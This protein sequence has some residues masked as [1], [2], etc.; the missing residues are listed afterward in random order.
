MTKGKRIILFLLVLMI[1]G[2]VF[3]A[4]QQN[5][6][7]VPLPAAPPFLCGFSAL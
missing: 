3:Y 7:Y 2:V 1:L 4:T 5:E 6:P